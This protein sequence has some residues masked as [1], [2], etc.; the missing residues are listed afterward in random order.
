MAPVATRRSIVWTLAPPDIHVYGVTMALLGS[1]WK[2]EAES[3]RKS[4]KKV[5]FLKQS[6]ISDT[7]VVLI[8][9]EFESSGWT[10][11]SLT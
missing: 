7:Q 4:G 8:I 5:H 6:G 3:S 11:A 10:L 2:R 9:N 1:K